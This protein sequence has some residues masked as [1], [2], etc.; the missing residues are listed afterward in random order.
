MYLNKIFNLQDYSVSY[1]QQ[2]FEMFI[3]SG[4]C[5]L[6]PLFIG[7]PQI[8]V[9]VLVNTMLIL[10]ALNLQ[11]YKLLPVILLPSLGVLISGLIFG[12][13]T[14]YLL[15]F[16]PFIWIGNSILVF[17][18]KYFKLGEKLNYFVA[19]FIGSALKATFLFSVAYILVKLSI[20]PAI[21]LTV[22]G[23][24]QLTTAL[25]GGLIAYPVQKIKKQL[26]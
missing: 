20:V 19:L 11:K 25:L 14:V 12:S 10:S 21:F 4:V 2:F 8:V 26:N 24:M 18:F 1:F 9:G 7:H 5:F 23:G 6:L 3:Y 15:Y 17:S 13:L 16:I 22:M